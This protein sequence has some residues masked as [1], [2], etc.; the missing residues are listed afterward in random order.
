MGM[1]LKDFREYVRPIAQRL[2]D[3]GIS[4]VDIIEAGVLLLGNKSFDDVGELV[5]ASKGQ[6]ISKI[7]ALQEILNISTLSA[8]ERKNLLALRKN[9]EEADKHIEK[10]RASKTSTGC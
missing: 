5:K 7:Y 2:N 8:K 4:V 1:S 10:L 6:P 3:R 9:L